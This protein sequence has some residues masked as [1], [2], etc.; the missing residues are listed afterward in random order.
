MQ[1]NGMT[2]VRENNMRKRLLMYNYVRV[3]VWECQARQWELGTCK[4]EVRR[5]KLTECYTITLQLHVHTCR[6][7]MKTSLQP[8]IHMLPLSLLSLLHTQVQFHMHI[9]TCAFLPLILFICDS[10]LSQLHVLPTVPDCCP[11]Q[12]RLPIL[13]HCG[14]HT[15]QR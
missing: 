9:C 2:D 12:I 11:S 14:F 3:R 1:P 4:E 15:S 7:I 6:Y 8:D 13:F 10:L 5:T